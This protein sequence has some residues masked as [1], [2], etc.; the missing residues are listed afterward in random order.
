VSIKINGFADRLDT[1]AMQYRHREIRG[2]TKI[3]LD[4]KDGT[5]HEK[6]QI[7]DNLVMMTDTVKYIQFFMLCFL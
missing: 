3:I 6:V 2:P 5:D 4:N 1:E 7:L